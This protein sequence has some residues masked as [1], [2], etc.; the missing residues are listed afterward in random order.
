[1]GNRAGW[2][3]QILPP[4]LDPLLGLS[5]IWLFASSGGW[6]SLSFR[7]KAASGTSPDGTVRAE[8]PPKALG[9]EVYKVILLLVPFYEALESTWKKSYLFFVGAKWF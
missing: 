4:D 7:G 6:Q 2:E 1:M 5:L 8:L 3:G 9:D